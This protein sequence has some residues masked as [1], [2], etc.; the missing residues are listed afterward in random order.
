[1]KTSN[2][3]VSLFCGLIGAAV[4]S[5][6]LAQ[7]QPPQPRH[8]RIIMLPRGERTSV[9]Q[10]YDPNLQARNQKYEALVEQGDKLRESNPGAAEA[11]Y[12]QATVTNPQPADAW[13]GLA[14]AA[15]AQQKPVQALSAYGKVFGSSGSSLYSTFPADVEALTRYG[16]LCENAGLH[17]AAIQACNQAGERLSPK[18]K[19][20]LSVPI[21]RSVT[22]SELQAVL[23]MVR[24]V[25]LEQQGKKAEA[26]SA[27]SKAA[28]SQPDDACVQF[29][30]GYG[31]QKT[32]QFAQANT[33]FL[34][35]A[36]LDTQ[37]IVKAAAEKELPAA[38]HP[39]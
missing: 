36:K 13:M 29:Y 12:R 35:A 2:L 6:C 20:P 33:A 31:Y 22:S 39:R 21:N 25:A 8:G 23:E 1:M 17:N 19:V 27:F 10:P 15:D 26:L 30:Q 9:V 32:E 16:T 34:K 4:I 3:A 7:R 37:G 14:R 28:V 24:G 38:M 5:Y 18:P 11:Y